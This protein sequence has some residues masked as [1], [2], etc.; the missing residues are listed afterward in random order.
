MHEVE[1]VEKAPP[2]A[3]DKLAAAQLKSE[4]DAVLNEIETQEHKLDSNF[5]KVGALLEKVREEKTWLFWG[6]RS[7]GTFVESIAGKVGKGRTRLYNC[8]R[9]AREL[10][11][12]IQPEELTEIGIGKSSALASAVKQSGGKK[13]TDE[14]IKAAKNPNTTIQKMQEMIADVYGAREE[15]EKG[16]WFNLAGIFFAPDE[17][18]EFLRC[19]ELAC[20]VDPPFSYVVKDWQEATAPQRKEIIW[21]L[22]AEFLSTHETDEVFGE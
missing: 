20:K 8:S 9:V 22:V 2:S 21:R 17:K 10:L 6:H 16:T 5:V 14:L 15:L 4:L 13:P 1:I 7:Y 11:P 3:A 19:V 18:A 12:Y